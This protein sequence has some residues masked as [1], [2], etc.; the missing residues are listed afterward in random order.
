MPTGSADPVLDTL[1][2][3]LASGALAWPSAG[4]SLFLRARAGAALHAARSHRP[5]CEQGF[6]PWADALARDGFAV[7]E[8][9][10]GRFELVMLL[11]PRQREESRA[12][13]ARA[14]AQVALGGVVL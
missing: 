12:L 8:S 7:S 5:V 11:A 13:L 14:V 3:P 2:L 9:N 4:S 10:T 6:K 1:F